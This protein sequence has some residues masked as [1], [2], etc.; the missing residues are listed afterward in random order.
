MRAM[1]NFYG[2]YKQKGRLYIKLESNIWSYSG[3]KHEKKIWKILHLQESSKSSTLWV[4]AIPWH[5][6]YKE[7]GTKTNISKSHKE[8]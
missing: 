1:K 4:C 6:K 3:P 7:K 2:I 8:Q 5:N